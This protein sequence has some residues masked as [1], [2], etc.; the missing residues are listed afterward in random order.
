MRPRTLGAGS[1]ALLLCS[2][3]CP[4]RSQPNVATGGRGP[5]VPP[6]LTAP[7]PAAPFAPPIV[8]VPSAPVPTPAIAM[9][10]PTPAPSFADD[11]SFLQRNGQVIVLEAPAGG[12]VALSAKYQGR[13]M[14]SAVEPNGQ[15]L[16][17][18]QRSFI[19][20]GKT[21]TQF[22][23]YGGE[24]R[25]WL[26]PEGGQFALYFAP[27]KPFEFR[28]WQT[29]NAFQTGEWTVKDQRA[30]SV[31]FERSLSLEN[32]SGTSFQLDVRRTVSLLDAAKVGKQLGIEPPSSLR[33]VAFQSDNRIT[34]TSPKA[35]TED[36]GLPSVWILAMFPP[37]DDTF[38]VV[39]FDRKGNGPIVNDSYFGKVPADRLRVD[40]QAG[41]LVFK[42]DGKHRSKI[43]LSPSRALPVLGS[44]SASARLL[45]IVQ[46]DKPKGAT[47][48]VNSMWEIQ[49]EP[50]GGDVVNSYNDGPTEPGKPALGGFYEMES[51]SPAAALKPR[52]SL[53]HVHRTYHFVGD[54]AELDRIAKK[55]L[56]VEVSTLASGG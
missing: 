42:C 45:T 11:L 16:G 17:W 18:V 34:N 5:G 19:E 39:P 50:Y 41:V 51:S 4:A 38:V 55:V 7:P 27:G 12:R 28:A 23:N 3:C 33:W 54:A 36:Q 26:G 15:S 30:T 56:G 44:Y 46:Y 8:P 32:H 37:A 53:Q 21:G 35:W 20:Q 13:I 52:E 14:T 10:A 9:P 24:D 2:S 40:A 22:D 49:Q 43:G 25:F 1:L 31:T 6:I 47:R 48:Y 29:P